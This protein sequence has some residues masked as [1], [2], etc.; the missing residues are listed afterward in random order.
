MI[1]RYLFCILTGLIFVNFSF[2]QAFQG[3]F[4]K[5]F[6]A[7]DTL[8]QKEVLMKWESAN[9]K[10]PEL[11]TSY[12]NYFYKKSMSEVLTLTTKEPQGEKFVITDSLNQTAG[13]IGSKNIFNESVFRK[14]I[15]KINEGITLYPDRLDMR[16]GK[17]YALGQAEYWQEFTDEIIKAVQ[18]SKVN[19]NQWTWTN[20]E[21]LPD[22]KKFFLSSLQTYQLDL[23]NT[24]D[25]SLLP[26]MRVI[27]NE[28]LKVYPDHVESL[29]NLAI[30]YFL[31]EEYDKGLEAL[32][33]A[34]KINPTDDIVLG[35]MAYG[36]T[37][38][39]NK[40]KAIEYYGKVAKHGNSDSKEWAK[41]QIEEM[42]K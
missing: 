31:T 15:N 42:K 37:M 4:Q 16:F 24:G 13:Y 14:G 30:T 10:D 33:K 28:V 21:K 23:Y 34:E 32:L 9:P 39:G 12:Y 7:N 19:T 20:D 38:K 26:Y 6:Q 17:I 27:A 2:S 18:Y 22:G 5:Y 8:K 29:S 36:Y 1:M 3:D 35:N 11:F 25:D 41:Q 40:K